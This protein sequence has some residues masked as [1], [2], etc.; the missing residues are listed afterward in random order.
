MFWI[1]PLNNSEYLIVSQ[2]VSDFSVFYVFIDILWPWHLNKKYTVL[3][4]FSEESFEDIVALITITYKELSVLHKNINGNNCCSRKYLEIKVFLNY[5]L[6][7]HITT[8]YCPYLQKCHGS[9][10]GSIC[11]KRKVQYEWTRMC[12][13]FSCVCDNFVLQF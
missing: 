11:F 9:H 13:I 6:P 3:G 1:N 8:K 5:I 2:H 7:T 4:I 10:Q 12:L